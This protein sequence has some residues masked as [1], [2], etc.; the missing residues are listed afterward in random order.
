MTIFI[1]YDTVSRVKTTL[2]VIRYVIT[3]GIGSYVLA[4]C[5]AFLTS[6]GGA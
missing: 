1:G 5:M 6:I 3:I 2:R 4:T